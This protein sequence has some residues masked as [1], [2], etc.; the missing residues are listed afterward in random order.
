ML[1]GF[2]VYLGSFYRRF[3]RCGVFNGLVVGDRRALLDVLVWEPDADAD[4][5][6][7]EVKVAGL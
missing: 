5:V 7:V 6:E 2:I 4:A 3:L 1:G